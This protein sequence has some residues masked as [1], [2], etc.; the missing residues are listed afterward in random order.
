[1]REGL[2]RRWP[3]PTRRIHALLDSVGSLD[4]DQADDARKWLLDTDAR[5]APSAARVLV[6]AARLGP[7]QRALLREVLALRKDQRQTLAA[8][9]E[10]SLLDDPQEETADTPTPSESE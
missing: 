6:A 10:S 1:M 3:D 2:P 9:L 7:R 5:P 4:S 8:A